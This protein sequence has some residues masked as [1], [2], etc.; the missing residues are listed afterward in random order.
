MRRCNGSSNGKASFLMRKDKRASAQPGIAADRFAREIVGF[1]RASSSALAAAECQT[2]RQQF[3]PSR[4]AH[5]R[6]STSIY[7]L[8]SEHCC[9]AS[10]KES[11]NDKLTTIQ[12]N[13]C[14]ARAA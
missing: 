12:P 10:N 14:L 7:N 3:A 5:L 9:A 6:F 1:L 8:A 2:V 4:S 11:S 13:R